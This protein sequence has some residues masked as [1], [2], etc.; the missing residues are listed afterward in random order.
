[1]SMSFRHF[2]NHRIDVVGKRKDSEGV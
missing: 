2:D 1:V